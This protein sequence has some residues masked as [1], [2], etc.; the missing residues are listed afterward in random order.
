V[1]DNCLRPETPARE[2]GLP[3]RGL[4]ARRLIDDIDRALSRPAPPP[5]RGSP[6]DLDGTDDALLAGSPSLLSV[7]EQGSAVYSCPTGNTLWLLEAL[8]SGVDAVGDRQLL[9][10]AA[11]R[12]HIRPIGRAVLP[13]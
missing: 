4:L 9:R 13:I 10:A 3:V 5:M 7:P 11:R 6:F 8:S 1:R 12:R 2:S